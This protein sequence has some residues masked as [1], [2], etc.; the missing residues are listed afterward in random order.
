ML[1]NRFI[2]VDGVRATHAG[3]ALIVLSYLSGY[4]FSKADLEI[5]VRLQIAREYRFLCDLNFCH[6]FDGRG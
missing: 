5:H 2:W 4:A 1:T 6:I 3:D